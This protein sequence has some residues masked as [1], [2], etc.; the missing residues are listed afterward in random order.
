MML[1]R[2]RR[3]F[4]VT[5]IAA[6]LVLN[7]LLAA[8]RGTLLLYDIY[9]REQGHIQVHEFPR[10]TENLSLIERLTL[11]FSIAGIIMAW[12]MLTLHPRAW[13]ATMA[14]QGLYL[15]AQLYDYFRGDPPYISLIITLAVVFYLNTR[16][17]QLVFRPARKFV[18]PRGMDHER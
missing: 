9:Q 18:R 6:L 5:I 15:I 17:V 11:P 14:L 3:P 4:G 13:F 2:R 12:G 7:G 1:R 8:V 16:D 10:L